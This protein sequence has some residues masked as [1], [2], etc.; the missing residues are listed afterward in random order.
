VPSQVSHLEQKMDIAVAVGLGL[1]LQQGSEGGRLKG[2][3]GVMG[4]EP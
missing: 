1:D 4:S 3:M 2:W